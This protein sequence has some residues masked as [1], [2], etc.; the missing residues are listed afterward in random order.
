VVQLTV[1]PDERDDRTDRVDPVPPTDEGDPVDQAEHAL[2]DDGDDGTVADATADDPAPVAD[3][4]TEAHDG[5]EPTGT[6]EEIGSGAGEVVA[7]SWVPLPQRISR[8]CTRWLDRLSG[9]PGAI[10][11]LALTVVTIGLCTWLLLETVHIDLV[12][13]NTTPTGGDMGAHVWGPNYLQHHLLPQGRLS[14]WTMDWYN[15][16]PAYQFYMVVPSLLIVLLHVGLHPVFGV[17]VALAAAGL[18]LAC[19]AR[20]PLFRFR[21]V[22]TVGAVVLTILVLPIAYNVSFKL[23]TVLGIVTMPLACW[24]MA[25]LADLP[26]PIPPFAAAASLLFLFNREPLYAGHGNIIGGNFTSTMAGEFAFS[27]SLTLSV[28]YL[29]VAARGL[30]TGKYRASAAVLF[31]LA[32]LCHLIPAFFVLACTGA[33]F[34][35]HPDKARLKWLATMVPVAGLLT[36]FW[37]VPFWWRSSYVNDMGWERL[38]EANARYSSLAADVGG[39]PSSYLYYLW[40]PSG[41]RWIMVGAAVGVI[42]S[43]VRRYRV[44]MVLSMAWL[45]VLA[46]FVL[47]PQYRLWNARLLPFLFLVVT[48]LA[49]IGLGEVIRMAGIVASGRVDRPFR[50]ISVTVAALAVAITLVSAIIPLDGIMAKTGT[51]F[52][53]ERVPVTRTE[54]VDGKP[55][56]TTVTEARFK[57]FGISLYKATPTMNALA[58]WS[59][60]NFTGLEGKEPTCSTDA[61]GKQTCVGGWPEYREFIATM[62]ALGQNPD[63]GCGRTM[64]EFDKDSLNSYGTTMSFMLL[65]YWT[66][67]CIGSQEGLYFEATPSVPYHFIMQSE[68]SAQG[69]GAQ[70]G[71]RYP[72]FNFDKGVE[73]LQLLGVKY[74]TA[75]SATA[76]AAA[77]AN[78]NLTQIAT[79]GRWHIYEVADAPEV[80]PLEYEPVVVDDIGETQDDWLP[81]ASAWFQKGDLA[82]PL[83]AHGPSSWKRVEVTKVPTTYRRLVSWLNDQLGRTGSFDQVPEQPKT[84]LPANTVTNIRHDEQSLSFDVSTPGV[85]VLVKT[86]Y[87]PNWKVSGGEGPYRVSPNLMVVVPTS[88]HVTMD[89]GRTPPDYLAYAMTLFGIAALVWLARR[90]PIEVSELHAGPLSDALDRL[91]SL[92]PARQDAPPAAAAPWP[93]DGPMA[94]ES[95]QDRPSWWQE[96]D[97]AAVGEASGGPVGPDPVVAPSDDPTT[98]DPV[99]TEDRTAADPEPPSAAEDPSP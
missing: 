92:P 36:A 62:A 65:P 43:I 28:L 40:P 77:D 78:P 49:A 47:L 58:G 23:V 35:L 12:L 89:F 16:F 30:R 44:G 87:F 66:D 2:S 84:K 51:K 17:I 57:L 15:G 91:V 52:G 19:W 59:R 93:P 24:A 80:A 97:P 42:V 76:V 10:A 54:T 55:T 33:L 67:G 9:D 4:P 37:V 6:P 14:G 79:A 50:P 13:R 7:A 20:E 73:H 32:G 27:I 18:A 96:D 26:F 72:G 25:K 41:M 94:P 85:P 90:K 86:S 98:A 48:M 68:L 38:P 34:L 5:A 69:S 64:W 11:E 75:I 29:G 82:V 95:D 63:Y 45:G 81:T 21:R 60:W 8:W 61:Q 71:I 70:N 74:Y 83:A 39:N 1:G 99:V 88:K 56:S 22:A 31:A 3:A 46:A 53:F